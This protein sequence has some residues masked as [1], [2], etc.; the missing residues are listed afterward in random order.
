MGGQHVSVSFEQCPTE[1]Y[2]VA[3]RHQHRPDR[4][5]KRFDEAL[6]RDCNLGSL[7]WEERKAHC[8]TG[9]GDLPPTG[10]QLVFQIFTVSHR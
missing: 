2:L 8:A 1:E 9:I 7:Y 4:R 5:I 6:D 3:D 10:G